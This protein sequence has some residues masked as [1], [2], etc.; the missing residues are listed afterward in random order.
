MFVINYIKSWTMKKRLIYF[1]NGITLRE[2]VQTKQR[3]FNLKILKNPFN[4]K[5]IPNK[6]YHK[7]KYK[8]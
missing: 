2:F 4:Q 1:R 7:I 3:N 8:I 5:P 6:Y